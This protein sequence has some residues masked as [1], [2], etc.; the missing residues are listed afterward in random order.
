MKPIN[1]FLFV[2]ILSSC[3]VNHPK[4]DLIKKNLLGQ[5]KQITEKRY[6]VNDKFGNI[7]KDTLVE[8]NV[9][10]Y[11]ENGFR[12]KKDL[13]G[14]DDPDCKYDEKGNPIEYTYKGWSIQKWKLEWDEKERV[15]EESVLDTDGNLK[16]K[17]TFKYDNNGNKI[18]QETQTPYSHDPKRFMHTKYVYKYD[19]N[20]NKI[21]WY[22][23]DNIVSSL[24]PVEMYK[25]DNN[26][27]ILEEKSFSDGVLSVIIKYEYD[28]NENLIEVKTNSLDRDYSTKATI[29]YDEKGNEIEQVQTGIIDKEP[30]KRENTYEYEFD[31]IGNWIKKIEYNDGVAEM[32]VKREIEYY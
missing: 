9:L 32:I 31:K 28:N 12:S 20:N 24:S 7:E 25:Y 19:N 6:L 1:I 8:T 21:G 30:I 10:L 3:S 23:E 15:I 13:R 22:E 29:R 14:S 26:G 27:N 18:E 11:D 4:T 17:R 16:L 2:V 5:V